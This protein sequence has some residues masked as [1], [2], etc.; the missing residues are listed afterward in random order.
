[1]LELLSAH[2][3]EPTSRGLANAVSAA[4][5]DGSLSEGDRLPPI[6]AVAGHLGVSPTTVSAAWAL[7]ARAGTLRTDGRRGTTVAVRPQPG[8]NRY[9]RALEGR[10]SFALDLSTGV[11]DP[12]LLPDLAPG[13]RRLHRTAGPGSYLDDPVLPELAERLESDWPGPIERLAIVDGAMDALDACAT[14]LLRFGDRVVVEQPCFPPLLD[15]LDALGVIP[16]GVGMDD[17][18]LLPEGVRAALAHGIR[19]VIL[20]PRA[21]NPTGVSLTAT[22]VAELAA[23]LEGTD[24]VVIEDDSAGAVAATAAISVTTLRPAHTIHIRSFS[25]SHGP[26][27]RIAAM[28]GPAALMDP[29]TERRFLG[30]GWT[31]RLLQGLLLDLLTH[32]ASI[33]QVDR[34][35]SAY[36]ERRAAVVT[37][38][39]SRGIA[40]AGQDGLNIWL[41][42][43]DEAAALVRL[44]SRGIGAAA[45][46]P[47]TLSSPS[48][49]GSAA[50]TGGQHHVRLTVGLVREEHLR[51][52]AEL[53]DAAAVGVWASP[54]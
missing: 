33:A 28:T 51:I 21:Q 44:A 46:S 38:L 6:R 4:I 49:S 29:M 19:A 30:Q 3:E 26:D 40:V 34:A 41:P 53:A 39:A 52:A 45:G 22:R 1:M 35:R 24:I 8:P 16:I 12:E 48:A 31:S 10:T 50:A 54:R 14:A 32:P 47:F 11:P 17:E 43:R 9:R 13:L 5:S 18:G 36:A 42:V 20:Q 7:L 27:L 37:G 23:V 15:L 2:L 25:K